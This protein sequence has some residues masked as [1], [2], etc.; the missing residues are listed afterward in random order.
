MEQ[1][2]YLTRALPRPFGD[3]ICQSPA[4]FSPAFEIVVLESVGST[5]I[6]KGNI[7]RIALNVSSGALLLHACTYLLSPPRRN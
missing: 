2:V 3:T 4:A 7:A 1:A 5:T 6:V